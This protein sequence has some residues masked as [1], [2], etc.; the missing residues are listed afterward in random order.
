[1]SRG[2]VQ[3]G[4]QV[5]VN[6]TNDSWYGR[7]AAPRQHLEIG[8]FRAIENRRPFLR[9]ANSGYSAVIDPLGRINSELGLF[10]E[11]I[12]E[13]TISGTL[14]H[15][16]YSQVGEWPNVLVVMITLLLATTMW[17]RNPKKHIDEREK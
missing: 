12:L 17:F 16:I 3:E 7:S 9:C 2:F 13:T 15:S 8:A 11:G 10:K 5:L 1:M 6:I 4:A 14:H